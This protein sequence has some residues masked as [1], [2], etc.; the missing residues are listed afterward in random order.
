MGKEAWQG[1][2]SLF[3]EGDLQ[4][5]VGRNLRRYREL[6]GLSQ[7]A[8]GDQLGFHP[9]YIGNLERGERNLTLRTVERIADMLGVHVLFL[10][11]DAGPKMPVAGRR[12]RGRP[13]KPL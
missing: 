5:I 9:N 2:W 7:E 12:R 3:V 4:R 13:A 8:F 10:L 6:H 11:T 1:R